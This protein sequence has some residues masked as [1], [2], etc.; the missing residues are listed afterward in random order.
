MAQP[1]GNLAIRQGYY[2]HNRVVDEDVYQAYPVARGVEDAVVSGQVGVTG[3]KRSR[4]YDYLL[5]CSENVARRYIDNLVQ[6]HRLTV[7][8]A[9]DDD[10]TAAA[11]AA[12]NCGNCV[13]V[14]ETDRGETGVVLLTSKHMQD[15]YSR[16]PELWLVHC[17]HKTN[18]FV[19]DLYGTY[20]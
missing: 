11:V 13:T 3:I 20:V 18:R 1:I 5:S 8:T 16:F 17:T 6:N 9:D 19:R 7:A 14:D 4:I 12:R 2:L 15:T 10:A